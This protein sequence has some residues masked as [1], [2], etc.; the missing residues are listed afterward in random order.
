MDQG[1]DRGCRDIQAVMLIMDFIVEGATIGWQKFICGNMNLSN[2][3]A[4]ELLRSSVRGW[5]T[6]GAFK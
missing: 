1:Q 3:A 4:L 2:E 6:L 5:G